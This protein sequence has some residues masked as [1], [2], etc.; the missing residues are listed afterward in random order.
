M[1]SEMFQVL[2]EDLTKVYRHYNRPLDR[3]IEALRRKPRHRPLTVLE[4]VSFS[5]E[6]GQSLGVIGDNGAGKSTLLKLLVGTLTPSRG[7]VEV[8]GRVTAL[9][10]LGAGFHPE[11]T[12]RQ[13]ILLNASLLG[14]SQ[15]DIANRE[16]GIIEFSELGDFIDRPV[17]T[18]S[19]GMYIRLGFA[20]ATSIDPDVLVIDEA[21]AVGDMAFQRKCV[22][23]MS[24]F[25]DQGKTMI[26]CSHSMYHVQE[27]CD[28]ALWLDKGRTR[29]VGPAG[30]VIAEYEDYCN[31]G[32]SVQE[33]AVPEISTNTPKDCR[34]LWIGLET[35]DGRPID[36]LTPFTDLVIKMEIEV[37]KDG[38]RPQFG[39]ALV[40][41]DDSIFSAAMTHH[42]GVVCGPYEAGR[43]VVVRLLI[44]DIQIRAGTY[45]LTGGVAE[46]KGLLWYESKHLWPVNVNGNEGLGPVTFRREWDVRDEL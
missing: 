27:L 9:L 5:L 38:I 4:G 2:A 3:L 19:S 23:R 21:L 44:K 30:E 8:L 37:L 15:Q 26:F 25:R 12:G 1:F 16:K 13:N 11:F 32:G 34:I 33:N 7:R 35:K 39:F 43:K 10:E 45:R 6:R 24:G 36:T 20:I 40:K 46:E 28:T 41:P 17:K 14:V 31:A 29:R 22:D 18:Y 42:D